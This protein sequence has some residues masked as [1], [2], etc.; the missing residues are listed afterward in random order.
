MIIRNCAFHLNYIQSYLNMHITIMIIRNLNTSIINY[1]KTS[2][3]SNW[4]VWWK[5]T[6]IHVW[7]AFNSNQVIIFYLI[8]C[9]QSNLQVCYSQF[10]L[11]ISLSL[12]QDSTTNWMLFLLLWTNLSSIS[13]LYLIKQITLHRIEQLDT[14]ITFI[15]SMNCLK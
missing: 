2:I 13:V 3:C 6:F 1:I 5:H 10:K 4:S 7:F 14:L 9:N 15:C 12:Y 11:W 8:S